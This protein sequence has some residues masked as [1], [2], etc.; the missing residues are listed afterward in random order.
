MPGRGTSTHAN[1]VD[2]RVG[3][4]LEV[5]QQR[6]VED[7]H[8]GRGGR[9]VLGRRHVRVERD[10]EVDGVRQEEERE[11]REQDHRRHERLAVLRRRR[12]AVVMTTP[13]C[14]DDDDDA[15]VMTELQ[16]PVT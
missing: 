7:E 16:Q 6:H 5:G 14:R 2:E 3:D 11:R 1:A 8:E 13:R 12:V 4:H 15:V 10:E 9:Q